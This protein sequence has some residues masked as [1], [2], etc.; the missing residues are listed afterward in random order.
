MGLYIYI[1]I[2]S[3]KC[4]ILRKL[5]ALFHSS[6]SWPTFYWVDTPVC[7][8]K[9]VKIVETARSDT[10]TSPQSPMSIWLL[11]LPKGVHALQCTVQTLV[12]IQRRHCLNKT[13]RVMN[14]LKPTESTETNT[15]ITQI[16]YDK[17]EH[18]NR[19]GEPTT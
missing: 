11:S 2:H 9:N 8:S 13:F 16:K 5:M 7:R 19:G 17:K 18:R 15:H 3:T 14:Q 6:P 10:T 1:I 12:H 4:P